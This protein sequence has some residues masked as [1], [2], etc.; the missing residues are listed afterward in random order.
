MVTIACRLLNCLQRGTSHSGGLAAYPTREGTVG[1]DEAKIRHA[2][3][4]AMITGAPENLDRNTRT[5]A[6]SDRRTSPA[7]G[8]LGE[9]AGAFSA[10][11]IE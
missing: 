1:G 2:L 7:M 9:L 10:R 5:S 6:L 4:L 8:C 11:A 3:T